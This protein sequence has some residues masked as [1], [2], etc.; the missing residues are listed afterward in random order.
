M[1]KVQFVDD[2]VIFGF[3]PPTVC[4]LGNEQDFLQLAKETIEFTSSSKEYLNLRDLKFSSFEDSSLVV[5]FS[6]KKDANHYGELVGRNHVKFELDPRYWERLFKYFILMS[7]GK[8]TYY[9][10]DY[11]N[12]LSDFELD[13]TCNFVCSSEF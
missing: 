4:L 11:E 13:Q 2:E 6:S 8:K 3:D 5:E 7:W 9:L 1:L 12:C 10:N